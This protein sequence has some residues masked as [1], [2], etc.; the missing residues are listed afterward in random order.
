MSL[1]FA[2]YIDASDSGSE[3]SLELNIDNIQL[4]NQDKSNYRSKVDS[5]LNID[6][7]YITPQ[8]AE[9]F[10]NESIIK[11]LRRISVHNAVI[12]QVQNEST[13]AKLAYIQQQRENE[14]K[15]LDYEKETAFSR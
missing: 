14:S 2:I 7:P 4:R 10:K 6:M 13:S 12:P 15:K 5:Y 11:D 9:N 3:S 8:E 1:L